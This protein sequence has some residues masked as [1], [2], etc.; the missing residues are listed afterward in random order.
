MGPKC[1]HPAFRP[2]CAAPGRFDGGDTTRFVFPQAWVVSNLAL[3]HR[4]FPEAFSASG[5]E[6]RLLEQLRWS[7]DFLAAC[8]YQEGS[9][10]AYTSMP[11]ALLWR[12]T[13][14]LRSVLLGGARVG[15]GRQA[16]THADRFGQ[17]VVR[18]CTVGQS[19]PV[20]SWL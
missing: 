10:V 5:Q 16:R 15:A 2:A 1:V 19:A 14:M 4:Q 3:A 20:Y 8:R 6:Q 13:T 17:L 11:G 18:G 9:L 7:A 12:R